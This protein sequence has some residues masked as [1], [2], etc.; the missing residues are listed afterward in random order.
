MLRT[1]PSPGRGGRSSIVCVLAGVLLAAAPARSGEVTQVATALEDDKP[2]EA[3][4]SVAYEY[5]AKRAAIKR[6][7]ELTGNT[8]G[9]GTF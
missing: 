2:V 7:W 1:S 3:F 5:T 6:E 9:F 4:L 8:T